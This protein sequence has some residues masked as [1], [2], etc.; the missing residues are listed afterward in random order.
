MDAHEH[1]D[2]DHYGQQQP[3]SSLN[4]QHQP[5]PN[6]HLHNN[7]NNNN[8]H[9]HQQ[10]PREHQQQSSVP[11]M[12]QHRNSQ[13]NELD[14]IKGICLNLASELDI[15]KSRIAEIAASLERMRFQREPG[16]Q[17]NPASTTD[18]NFKRKK[19][20]LLRHRNKSER[21]QQNSLD[22]VVEQVDADERNNDG[23]RRNQRRDFKDKAVQPNRM[24]DDSTTQAADPSSED[25]I[26]GDNGDE[27]VKRVIRRRKQPYKKGYNR[28]NRM[29]SSERNSN[30]TSPQ[31]EAD[32]EHYRRTQKARN[33]PKAHYPEL[34]EAEMNEIIQA[35]TR[36]FLSSELESVDRTIVERHPNVAKMFATAILDHAICDVTSPTKL[37]EIATNLSQA[38]VGIEGGK[39]FERGF[40]AALIDLAKREDDIAIDAPRYMD[41]LGQVIGQCL[42]P[43]NTGRNKYL[44]RIFLRQ[45]ISAYG[46]ENV[47]SGQKLLASI[48]RALA[49]CKSERYA[50]QV[51]EQTKNNLPPVMKNLDDDFLESQDI[52]F[53]TKSFSPEPQAT[54]KTPAEMEKF[55]DDVTDLVENNCTPQKLDGLLKD[56]ELEPSDKIDHLG[57]LMYAIVRGCLITDSGDYK[58]DTEALNKYS[59]LLKNQQYK[60]EQQDAIALQALTALTKLWHSY[61]CPQNLMSNILLA[62]HGHGGASYDALQTWLNSDDLKN[63]P[64]IGAA[65]LS[66]KRCIEDLGAKCEAREH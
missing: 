10:P 7:N 23:K 38:I 27:R 13:Q 34:T 6:H 21:D 30:D 26:E 41:T 11:K 33:G 57:T 59:P 49:S 20:K 53:L 61:N 8:H 28:R 44:M 40:Y 19:T 58:L 48:F 5:H 3:S 4:S 17:N 37:S 51:Y 50:A 46:K 54:K 29:D 43:L 22:G 52:K 39:K 35:M 31:N 24:N 2:D 15:V 18:N 9:H 42:V 55:A 36:D 16:S 45:C 12:Q 62:L 56:M 63:I 65:R 1:P 14:A 32:E 64:G 25:K 47:Q 66:A 60:K